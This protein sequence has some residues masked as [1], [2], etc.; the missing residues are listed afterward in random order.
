[1]NNIIT[2]PYYVGGEKFLSENT[3]ADLEF[4]SYTPKKTEYFDSNFNK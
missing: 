2:K 3:P 1:M 4:I